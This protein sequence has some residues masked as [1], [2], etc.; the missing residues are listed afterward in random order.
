[1]PLIQGQVGPQA[2]GDGAQPVARVGKL[3]DLVVSE[4]MGRYYEQA[5][6][7]N[8]FL[9]H[10]ST[11][12]APVIYSTAAGTGGPLIWNA[13]QTT[14]VV[15]LAAAFSTSVVTTVAGSLGIT[16]NTGQ[17]A[18]PGTTTAI[19]TRANCFIGGGASAA[20]PY[21]I[22]TPAAAGNFFFPLFQVHT[23]ALTVDTS[24]ATWIDIGGCIICP[25]NCWVAIAGSATL[26]T[27]QMQAGLLYTE[28]PV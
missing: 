11:V 22:G 4:L 12:T 17:S 6:R 26:T 27:L 13:S 20:T 21:T 5:Y 28:T 7:R 3:G 15:L 16:G 23:G 14:N 1:M 10:C 9:A 19:G 18:A 2:L 8:L 24:A 25:P